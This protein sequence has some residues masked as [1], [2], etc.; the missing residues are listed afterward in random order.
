MRFT[1]K[2]EE[3]LKALTIANRAVGSKVTNPVLGNLKIDLTENGLFITGSNYDLTIQTQVPYKFNG[4]EIIRNYKEG[5]IL[6]DSRFL[7]EMIRKLDSEE[8]TFDVV[9]STDACISAGECSNYTLRCIRAEEYPDLDLE[10]SGVKLTLSKETFD[11]L[12]SQTAFAASTKEQKPVLTAINLDA[13]NGVLVATATDS[14]RMARKEVKIDTDVHFVANVP[15]K[16]MIEI[17]H[18][19]ENVDTLDVSFSSNKALFIIGRTVVATR[20]IAGEYPNTK[21]ILAN[22]GKVFMSLEVNANNMTKAIDRVNPFSVDRANVVDLTMNENRVEVSAR[23]QQIGH[24]IERIEVFKYVGQ[25][26]RISFNS[27]FVV[28]AIKS[29]RCE[30]VVFE[31]AGEMKSFVIKNISDDSVIQIIT[32]VRVY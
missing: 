23:S 29:L 21:N 5:A 20:L 11:A 10:P 9:D 12:V 27:E 30:D 1:I 7:L 22:I 3:F 13:N 18:L 32:P 25:D 14:A 24:A 31:F 28:A 17:N 6:T 4:Q 19:V 26:L 16:M 15:A 8:I 2:R